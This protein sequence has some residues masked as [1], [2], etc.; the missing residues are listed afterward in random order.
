M[1][2]I[3]NLSLTGELISTG[4]LI[5]VKTPELVDAAQLYTGKL[6]F[7]DQKIT[8]FSKYKRIIKLFSFF[9]IDFIRII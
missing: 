9:L 4:N 5:S 8:V 2:Q 7:L 6:I 3:C 1:T